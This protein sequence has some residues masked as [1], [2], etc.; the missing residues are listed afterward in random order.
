MARAQ[1]DAAGA[2]EALLLNTDG[3]VVEGTAS[4]LFWIRGGKVFTPPL[5]SGILPGTTRATIL[6]ICRRLKIS[7]RE[8]LPRPAELHRADG[9]FL[10]VSSIGVAEI[11]SLDGR[12]LRHSPLT[13]QI[14]RAYNEMLAKA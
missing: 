9:V 14:A 6:E 4:N 11:I 1:A 10:T 5:A 12:R 8:I 3:F 2:R 7:A 13:R